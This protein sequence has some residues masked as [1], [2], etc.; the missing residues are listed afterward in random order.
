M[1]VVTVPPGVEGLLGLAELPD[2]DWADNWNRIIVDRA[3]K[4]RLL[5]YLLFALAH[6]GR[7]SAVRLPLHGLVVLHGPPGTGKT[8]LAAGL[9]QAAAEALG[10]RL[11]FA[12]IDANA[13]PSQMLGESQRAVAR[14]LHRTIPDLAR[15]GHPLVVR[16]DEV[17]SLAVNRSRAS[18]DTNPV[19][20][21]RATDAL[22]AGVDEVA[23]TCPN[24]IF[25][26]TTNF[27]VGVDGAFL[28][29]ADLV[30]HIGLPSVEATRAILLDT[31]AEVTSGR[32]GNADLAAIDELAHACVE[33][34]LDARQL[35]KL[36][37][38]AIVTRAELAR[39]PS[40]LTVADLRAALPTP[41]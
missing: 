18:M 22:L 34:S 27:E 29:R 1:P 23:A 36:A 4:E 35:R 32:D 30:E 8:T 14:L 17:E 39:D 24:V 40:R 10:G 5:N 38:R 13:F 11:L 25:I 7:I 16:L 20:V 26:A 19:D 6:R 15:R 3:L 28:S 37:L 21:H 2:D 33:Q 31:L 41:P 12:S 9:A